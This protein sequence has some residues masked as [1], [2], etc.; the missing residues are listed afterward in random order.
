MI[1]PNT[2]ALLDL[3]DFTTPPSDEAKEAIQA[4]RSAYQQTAKWTVDFTPPGPEQTMALR[5]LL[6]AK[7]A[8]V[9]AVVASW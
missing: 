9:R 2:Q 1:H 8:A 5:K 3:F 6:E 4:V 7:D